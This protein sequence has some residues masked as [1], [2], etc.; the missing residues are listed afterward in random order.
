MLANLR[1]R[2]LFRHALLKDS[3]IYVI[4]EMTAK[5]VPFLLLPYLTRMLGSTGFGQL[6]YYQSITAFLLIIMSLSQSGAITRYYYVYGRRGLGN[7]MF[8]GGLYSVMIMLFGMAVSWGLHDELLYY[9]CATAF[10]QSLVQNQLALRQCQKL[11]LHY[12]S[13]QLTLAVTNVI[14]TLLLFHYLAENKVVERLIAI[15]LSYLLSFLLALWWTR[16]QLHL[17]VAL[18]AQR[19]RLAMRYIM[20]LG[21][22]LLLHAFSYTIKG[23]FDRL[24]IYQRF[25]A[26]ELGIYA[27]GVQI[28]S[29]VTIVIMAVNSAGVPYLY[30]NLK[31]GRLG[32]TKLHQLFW[33]SLAIPPILAVIT[34]ALPTALF[35]WLL[36]Q[37]FGGSH[38]YTVIFVFA[39][40]LSIPYLLLVNFLFYHA[41]N[42][43]ISIASVASTVVYLAALLV[44]SHYSLAW[45]PF[46]SIVSNVM[47]LPMLYYFTLTV[48]RA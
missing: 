4:G 43:Q 28:A 7:V 3:L 17:R 29:A 45:V 38:Y 46:A 1:L 8:V 22:P 18:T 44:L 20:V 16:R 11:P 39:F 27:A 40:A 31:S 35:T 21:L 2:S 48:E 34:W 37:S 14:F 10:L 19:L 13:I 41:K 25:S 26:H 15:S 42:T 33:L 36:G 47:L 5:A 6:S 24:I 12:F 23:Q 9:C 30:E 32:L